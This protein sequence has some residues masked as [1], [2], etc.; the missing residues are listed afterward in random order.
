[1]SVSSGGPFNTRAK[2]G[3]GFVGGGPSPIL[4][5]RNMSFHGYS[6]S[7][8]R[9]ADSMFSTFIGLTH[10]GEDFDYEG[11]DFEED[12]GEE[13]MYDDDLV[14]EEVEYMIGEIASK[15]QTLAEL[16]LDE[17]EETAMQDEIS[18]DD[19]ELKKEFSVSGGIA[20]YTGP[21]AGSKK[22]L[23]QQRKL[24]QKMYGA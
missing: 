8:L 7:P 20:G 1:M 19:E 2:M 24:M 13:L 6:G 23:A 18:D 5:P 3:A 16:V 4:N 21:L 15:M 10:N 12:E 14:L 11:T 22:N 9:S 17:D